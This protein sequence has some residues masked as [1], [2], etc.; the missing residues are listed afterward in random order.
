MRDLGSLILG[1][2]CTFVGGILFGRIKLD[3][4]Y[5]PKQSSTYKVQYLPSIREPK[6][7]KFLLYNGTVVPGMVP[8]IGPIRG[9][10]VD[11]GSAPLYVLYHCLRSKRSSVDLFRF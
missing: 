8:G 9:T 4:L 5:P 3:L 6:L 7:Q 11:G 1:K 2:Y 10:R